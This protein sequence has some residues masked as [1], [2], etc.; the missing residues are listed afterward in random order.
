MSEYYSKTGGE[1]TK[2]Y[3][4]PCLATKLITDKTTS[5]VIIIGLL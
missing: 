4:K 1:I 2:G 3:Y 5:V